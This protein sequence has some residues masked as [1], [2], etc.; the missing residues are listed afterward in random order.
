[1]NFM[2]NDSTACCDP[3]RAEAR[4]LLTVLQTVGQA[5]F[6]AVSENSETRHNRRRVS[7]HVSWCLRE[8]DSRC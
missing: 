4:L 2:Y 6:N 8:R 7:G 5:M 3:Q 1:M